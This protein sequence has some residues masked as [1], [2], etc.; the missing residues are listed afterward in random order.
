MVSYSQVIRELSKVLSNTN[1]RI[2]TKTGGH[3]KD[4]VSKKIKTTK[5]RTQLGVQDPVWW[6]Q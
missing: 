6:M 3:I 1:V 4:L 2:V 5:K